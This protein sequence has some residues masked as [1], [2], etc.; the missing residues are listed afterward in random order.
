VEKSPP[1]E[2]AALPPPV[3]TPA[4]KPAAVPAQTARAP[5]PAAAPVAKQDTDIS[6]LLGAFEAAEANAAKQEAAPATGEARVRLESTPPL[7]VRVGNRI[8]GTTPVVVR[9]PEPGPVDIELFDNSLGLTR[10]E[11]IDLR[12]GDNGVRQITFGKGAIALQVQAGITVYVDGKKVGMAPFSK[13][14]PLYEGKHPVR[15]VLGDQE[16]RRL[17]TIT[18]GETETLEFTFER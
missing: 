17:V 8:L 1:S 7:R 18:P 6:K 13:P 5:R 15:L 11:H 9:L 10:L 14:L 2:P 3:A 4:P 12:A 16:E